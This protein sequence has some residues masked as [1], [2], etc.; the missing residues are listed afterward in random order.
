[1]ALRY[2][3]NLDVFSQHAGKI[4][5]ARVPALSPVAA[6]RKAKAGGVDFLSHICPSLYQLPTVTYTWHVGLR[7]R[8]PRPLARAVKRLSDAPCST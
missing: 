3:R 4:T 1:L 5:V 7:I 8:L 6:Y 2:S